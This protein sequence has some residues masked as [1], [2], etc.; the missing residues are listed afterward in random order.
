MS[1]EPPLSAARATLARWATGALLAV[2]ALA[3]LVRPGVLA[4]VLALVL[5]AASVAVFVR[6]D[7]SSATIVAVLL[8]GIAAFFLAA[9]VTGNS[10]WITDRYSR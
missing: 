10:H 7:R 6:K 5:A 3:L 2:G 8:L 1:Q 4:K 9:L